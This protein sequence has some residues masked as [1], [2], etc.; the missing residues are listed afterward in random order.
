MTKLNSHIHLKF[1]GLSVLLNVVLVSFPSTGHFTTLSAGIREGVREM[2]A[3]H[4]VPDRVSAVVAKLV[5][6][7]TQ[8]IFPIG[9]HNILIHFL[10]VLQRA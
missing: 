3:L 10:G 2:L 9:P 7:D 8:V 6:Q 1:L 4:M 5:A